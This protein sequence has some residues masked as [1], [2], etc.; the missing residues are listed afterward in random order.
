MVL[1]RAS[2]RLA[3]RRHA[4][5]EAE[6]GDRERILRLISTGE[7]T[8]E[9][10][11][12]LARILYAD[13]ARVAPDR[14]DP[15][16][17]PDMPPDGELARDGSERRSFVDVVTEFATSRDSDDRE[18]I[19]VYARPVVTSS[20]TRVA[21]ARAVSWPPALSR[22]PEVVPLSWTVWRRG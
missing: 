6:G 5:A 9:Q 17:A 13:E 14:G 15:E 7:A 8:V 1:L 18:T 2:A 19:L 20:R 12:E 11:T 16:S 3:W 4:C 22:L 10:A 21:A